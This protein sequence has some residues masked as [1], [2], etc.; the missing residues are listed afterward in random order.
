MH[1]VPRIKKIETERLD[2]GRFQ[3]FAGRDES[4]RRAEKGQLSSAYGGEG[5]F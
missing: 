4:V 1:K 2:Q 3:K 5:H